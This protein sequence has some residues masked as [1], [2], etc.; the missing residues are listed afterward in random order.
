MQ[1][2]KV[3]MRKITVTNK[4]YILLAFTFSYVITFRGT[5]FFHV[6]LSYCLISFHFSLRDPFQYLLYGWS[7]SDE[8]S[9]FKIW[10]CLNFT[11]MFER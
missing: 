8:F 1:F 2:F 4:K 5:P 7:A 3:D 9:L 6:D 11:S 10:E